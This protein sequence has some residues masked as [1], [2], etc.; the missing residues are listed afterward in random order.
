MLVSW[1]LGLHAAPFWDQLFDEFFLPA[2]GRSSVC[3][4]WGE[5]PSIFFIISSMLCAA[6]SWVRAS[7]S[8]LTYFRHGVYRYCMGSM[9][10]FVSALIIV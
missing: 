3:V 9:Y 5:L 1:K 2:S 8:A 4:S 10:S 7:F 6:A